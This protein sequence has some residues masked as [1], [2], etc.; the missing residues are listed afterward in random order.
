M[1][2]FAIQIFANNVFLSFTE[3]GNGEHQLQTGVGDEIWKMRSRVQADSE[4]I[5]TG[6]S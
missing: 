1:L 4:D 6:E 2:L 3:K 5:K